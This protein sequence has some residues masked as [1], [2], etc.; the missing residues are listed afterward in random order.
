MGLSTSGG[1]SRPRQPCLPPVPNGPGRGKGAPG[2]TAG[3]GGKVR[4]R[5]RCSTRAP[6][7]VGLRPRRSAAR[8]SRTKSQRYVPPTCSTRPARWASSRT[9]SISSN[10]PSGSPHAT[11]LLASRAASVSPRSSASRRARSPSRYLPPTHRFRR[12]SWPTS[13]TPLPAR[14]W[15]GAAR[16]R[17]QLHERPAPIPPSVPGTRG[18]PASRVNERPSPSLSPRARRHS[19]AS[20]RAAIASSLWSVR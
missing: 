17:R 16:A 5:G 1:S 2:M 15:P 6:G 9:C 8:Q 13:R 18:S 10:P 12:C 19:S 7:P 14:D 20:S 3:R 11:I 4:A